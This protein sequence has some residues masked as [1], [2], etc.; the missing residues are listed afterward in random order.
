MGIFDFFSKKPTDAKVDK[1][2]KRMLNEHHQQQVRQEATE[3]LISYGI[4]S[5]IAGLVQ[6][7]GVNFADTIKNE[8]E[9]RYISNVL[10]EHFGERSIEPL[11]QFIRSEQTISAAI[12][13][14]ARLISP[15][16]LVTL[17]LETLAQ[18]APEDHRTISARLQ[19]IDALS[20]YEDDRIVPAVTPYCLDHD[21]DVRDK[22]MAL[23]V[24]RVHD[25]SHP[26][27]NAVVQSLIEALADPEAPGRIQR[28]A[29]DALI[30]L[31]ADLSSRVNEL[32]EFMPD[33]YRIDK[34]GQ[35]EKL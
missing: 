33:G 19:L 8:Q 24:A 15:E 35:I 22:V 17:L 2:T 6:R 26:H 11:S 30:S 7:L 18:Y 10:V 5:A 16:K 21:D 3:E 34:Q 27:Y 31:K 23:L 25:K 13:T 29:A 9:K 1:L 12:L 14:L 28:L 32:A 4:P 20:E